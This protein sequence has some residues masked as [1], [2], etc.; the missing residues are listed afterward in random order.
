M[1]TDFTEWR[2]VTRARPLFTGH[3]RNH[4]PVDLGLYDLGLPEVREAQ[5]TLARQYGVHGFR[6][7]FFWHNGRRILERP[8]NEIV[9]RGKPDV[10][11]QEGSLPRD[12]QE[13][14]ACALADWFD[15]PLWGEASLDL[16]MDDIRQL[17]LETEPRGPIGLEKQGL[18]GEI[19]H[20][21][22]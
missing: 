7:Y 3:Y 17:C 21:R 19:E 4:L 18:G 16:L 11:L 6:Y 13:R 2:N 22:Q 20:W 15:Q 5:D 10:P 12:H 14:R 1:G 8:F 9:E